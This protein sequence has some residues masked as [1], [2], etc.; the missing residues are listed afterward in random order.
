MA[1]RMRQYNLD[2]ELER[3]TNTVIGAAIEVHR[4][5]GPGHL[6][7]MYIAAMCVEFTLRNIPFDRQHHVRLTYKNVT[8]GE[9]FVDL[10]VAGMLV[11]ELKA[12]VELLPVHE[13]QVISYL[14]LT[15]CKLGLL[16]NFNVP[17]LKDGIRR[18]VHPSVL[19]A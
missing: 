12:V 2:P 16:I 5:L 8:I 10:L 7:A 15:S 11:V 17:M 14:K 3:W 6:E 19:N 13:A 9:G 1:G 4:I 18:L